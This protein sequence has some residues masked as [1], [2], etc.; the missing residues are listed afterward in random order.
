[1]RVYVDSVGCRLNQ[2]E[3]ESIA[4]QFRSQ[5]YELVTRV[6]DAQIVVINTC[7][8][9]GKAVADSRHLIRHAAEREGVQVIATGCWAELEP[10]E[11]TGLSNRVQVVGNQEKSGIG[12]LFPAEQALHPAITGRSPLPGER[13]RTR[14]FIKVQDGCDNHCTFCITRIA[15]GKAHSRTAEEVLQDIHWAAEGGAREAVLTGV[16]LSSWGMDFQPKLRLADLV[17]TILQ[18]TSIERLRLSSLEPWNLDE[19][20]F[21]L[22]E[23]PRMCR[24]IHLPLQSGSDAILKRMGR[25]TNREQFAAVV[26]TARQAEPNMAVS[27]DIIVG[28]PGEEERHF[29]ESLQFIQ[30][31]RFESGHVFAYSPRPGTPAA[32]LPGRV[33]DQELKRRSQRLRAV[34]AEQ[35]RE[36]RQSF[37]G[38]E[39]QVLWESSKQT[40]DGMWQLRGLSDNYLKVVSTSPVDRWNRIDRVRIARIEKDNMFGEIV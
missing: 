19:R 25:L 22:W 23:D 6:E 30:E 11:I 15:R 36:Y 29:E 26:Q 20:F 27:T 7:A 1:M 35:G 9:T 32:L 16:N 28:F 39:L 12:L 34:L 37:I 33:P 4:A 31:M 21:Q 18:K 2:S 40:G 24:H 10:G 38:S 17:Q 14:A 8:V 5:G 3:I 13:F